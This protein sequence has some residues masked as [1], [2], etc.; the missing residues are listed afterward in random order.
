[1]RS[2]PL[3]DILCDWL[4]AHGRTQPELDRY[5]LR[6]ARLRHLDPTPCPQCHLDAPDGE[7]DQPLLLLERDRNEAPLFCPRCR[8]IFRI[9]VEHIPLS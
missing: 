7:A 4:R 5:A 1:M 6:F 9:P 8:A 3:L 2:M